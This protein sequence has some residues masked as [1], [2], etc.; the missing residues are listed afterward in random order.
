MGVNGTS[1]YN[2]NITLNNTGGG[3]LNFNVN[4][5]ASSTLVAGRTISAGSF[6]AG[7]LV[8]QRFGAIDNQ[9]ILLTGTA[10]LDVGPG[11]SF[12]G[13]VDFRAPQMYLNGVTVGG[14]ASWKNRE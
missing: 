12:A 10:R 11:A 13:N 5:S 9:T 8:L 3:L 6:P 7:R 4:A 1:T 14:P 2:G